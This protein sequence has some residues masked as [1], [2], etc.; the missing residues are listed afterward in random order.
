MVLI[1]VLVL[2]RFFD[3]NMHILLRGVLF[4]GVG[5]GFLLTNYTI[6]QQQKKNSYEN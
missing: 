2:C 6:V 3:M 1:A 4:V 5:I